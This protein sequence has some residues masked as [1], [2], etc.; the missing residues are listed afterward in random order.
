MHTRQHPKPYHRRSVFGDGR[1]VPLDRERRARYRFLLHAHIHAGRLPDKQGR[2]GLALLK[3]L[4]VDGRCDPSHAT[5]A[6][7][8]NVGIS[9]VQRATDTMR[10]LGLLRWDRRLVRNGWRVEQTSNAYELVPAVGSIPP[11][12]PRFS[13]D[14]HSD[15]ETTKITYSSCP[16][17]SVAEGREA[18]TTLASIAQHRSAAFVAAWSQ[19]HG[20]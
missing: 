8:A 16:T 15:R 4:S 14:I 11:V 7:D 17:V 1:R 3:R 18:Q 2:V 20:W 9:T 5:L 6:T 12:L 10:A 13:C 19:R